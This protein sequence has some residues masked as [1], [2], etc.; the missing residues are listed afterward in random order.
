M[1]TIPRV[2]SVTQANKMLPLLTCIVKSIVGTWDEIIQLRQKLEYAEKGAPIAVENRWN[3]E[4]IK[5]YLNHLIDKVNGYIHEVEDLGCFVQEFKRGIINFPTLCNGRKVF[6]CW[7]L[8]EDAVVHW[9]ELDES[10]AD[11]TRIVRLSDF[12]VKAPTDKPKVIRA[13]EEG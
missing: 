13:R 7:V 11:R 8:G 4:E 9:H 6:L 3:P 12:L 10:F 2:I 5:E 1:M